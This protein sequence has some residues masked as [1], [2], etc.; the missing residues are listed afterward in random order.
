MLIFDSIQ[1]TSVLNSPWTNE[2][3][4]KIRDM[5]RK[6]KISKAITENGVNNK[7]NLSIT[8]TLEKM[9]QFSLTGQANH[10]ALNLA[11]WLRIQ[12]NHVQQITTMVNKISSISVP[13]E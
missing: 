7:E 3:G 2:K 13:N 8:P 4:K 5:K 10:D 9:K 12:N 11:N 6:L 1:S